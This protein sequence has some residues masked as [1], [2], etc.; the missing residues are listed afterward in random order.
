MFGDGVPDAIARE[1][2]SATR[3]RAGISPSEVARG[4]GRTEYGVRIERT[5]LIGLYP[6][7]RYFHRFDPVGVVRELS[8]PATPG[9]PARWASS[10]YRPG[11]A[12]WERATLTALWG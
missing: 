6:F 9:Y 2:G 5:V 7:T 3:R 12:T 1:R 8:G 11:S 4:G 10:S